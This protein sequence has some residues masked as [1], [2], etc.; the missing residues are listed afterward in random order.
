MFYFSMV[1]ICIDV[2]S[3][4]SKSLLSLMAIDNGNAY[5]ENK[6]ND[7]QVFVLGMVLHCQ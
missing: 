5:V 3:I 2:Q 6:M 1:L 7:R 4:D